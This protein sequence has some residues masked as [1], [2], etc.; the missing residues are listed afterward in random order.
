MRYKI[1]NKSLEM[2]PRCK[3][4]KLILF[5]KTMSGNTPSYLCNMVPNR[6]RENQRYPLR[7]G[8]DI[9][10]MFGRT[11]KMYNSFLPY[12]IREWNALPDNIKQSETV[13]SFKYALYKNVENCNKLFY[14][15]DRYCNVIHARLRMECSAL[16]AHLFYMFIIDSPRCMCGYPMETTDHFIL[17]CPLYLRHRRK[18]FDDIN[19]VTN[20][21][22]TIDLLLF[23]SA[24]ETFTNN[25]LIFKAVHDYIKISGRF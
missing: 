24:E 5:K 20:L 11:A 15:G 8:D 18:L 16:N 1:G 12:S 17:H 2:L 23:G 14:Y 13:T 21:N 10:T 22:V 4:H 3:N 9:I 7:N 6:V 19:N 25:T